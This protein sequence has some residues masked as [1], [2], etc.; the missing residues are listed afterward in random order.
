M[1]L[2]FESGKGLGQFGV[3]HVKVFERKP[4]KEALF[5]IFLGHFHWDDGILGLLPQF[6]PVPSQQFNHDSHEGESRGILRGIPRHHLPD[7]DL[8][9]PG[10][11]WRPFRT[12]VKLHW[13][14]F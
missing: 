2:L 13:C 8:D 5:L 10:Q 7:P 1:Y 6:D 12:S 3:S 4:G 11:D 9:M 14:R